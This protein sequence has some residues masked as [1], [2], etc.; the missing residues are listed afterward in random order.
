MLSL[1][2]NTSKSREWWTFFTLFRTRYLPYYR[3]SKAGLLVIIELINGTILASVYQTDLCRWSNLI[4]FHECCWCYIADMACGLADSKQPK[5]TCSQK[6]HSIHYGTINCIDCINWRENELNEDII[7][8]CK[9]CPDTIP[10][11]ILS[12][13]WVLF[14]EFRLMCGL[15]NKQR[16]LRY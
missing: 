1:S 14:R 13:S 16:R 3:F 6:W 4:D 11:D 12:D 2:R 10:C 5:Q 9:H 7:L 8:V 15:C